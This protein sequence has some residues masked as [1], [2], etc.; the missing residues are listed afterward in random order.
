MALKHC[1]TK[2]Y[3]AFLFHLPG[4]PKPGHAAPVLQQQPMGRRRALAA[5][6]LVKEAISSSNA[7]SAFEFRITT[8][9]QT[10]EEADAVVKIHARELLKIKAYIDSQSWREAQISL[11]ESSSLL[12]QDLYTIIQAKPGSQRPQLRK[13]YSILFNN[14][15]M[16]NPTSSI[17]Q[18]LIVLCFPFF[19][20]HGIV[21]WQAY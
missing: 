1:S 14:V 4:Y 3:Y 17:V 15:S 20:I 11:R 5:L 13:L 18:A 9:D 6:L 2:P 12:K 21:D 10:L 16:V 8:P 19:C 7:A